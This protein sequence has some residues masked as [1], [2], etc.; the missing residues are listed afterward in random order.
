MPATVATQAQV[1]P[2]RY[3]DVNQRFRTTIATTEARFPAGIPVVGP[4][5]V[6][7]PERTGR[8]CVTQT[9]GTLVPYEQAEAHISIT[10]ALGP[11]VFLVVRDFRLLHVQWI[12]ERLLYLDRNMGRVAGID[13]IF[14]VIERKWLFQKWVQ[15]Y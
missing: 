4:E 1:P 12:N 9:D 13:E 8:A 7:S 14:D 5:T 10:T 15:Y 3:E 11:P 6:D 2:L